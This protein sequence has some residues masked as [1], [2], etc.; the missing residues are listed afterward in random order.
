MAGKKEEGFFLLELLVALALLL[1]VI[2]PL[3]ELLV[4]AAET[5]ARARRHTAAAFL[6]RES[7]ETVRSLG[8]YR[9]ERVAPQLL[10]RGGEFLRAVDVSLLKQEAVSLKRIVVT[11]TWQERESRRKVELVT[12]LT[13]GEVMG[14]KGLP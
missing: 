13:G 2:V 8:Y 4:M 10:R 14:K 9:A 5:Q 12:Y 3:L 7:M 1:V 6:A 11:V